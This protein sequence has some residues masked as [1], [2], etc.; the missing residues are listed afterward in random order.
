MRVP[1]ISLLGALAVCQALEG[2]AKPGRKPKIKWPNDVLVNNK[3]L[4]GIL[5]EMKS[6]MD[7]VHFVVVGIGMNIN[8]TENDFSEELVAQSTSMQIISGQVQN[9]ALTTAAI[10]NQF[11]QVYDH[12]LHYGLEP[13]LD[14]LEKRSAMHGRRVDVNDG[15]TQSTGLALGYAED[16]T[17]RVQLE[18][19]EETRVCCGDVNLH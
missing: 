14:E 5:C 8:M 10:L 11:E 17:L 19:G 13:L 6:E 1:Q 2:M 18:N 3:K 15:R 9:R 7:R 16:G 12:W 4:A